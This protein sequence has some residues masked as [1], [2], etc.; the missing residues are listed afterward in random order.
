MAYFRNELAAKSSIIPR[1]LDDPARLVQRQ[2]LAELLIDLF[3]G[4]ELR[5]FVQRHYRLSKLLP[6]RTESTLRFA[7]A[8]VDLLDERSELDEELFIRLMQSRP[9]RALDIAKAAAG[10]GIILSAARIASIQS[11][12]LEVDE[13]IEADELGNRFRSVSSTD[14]GPY[15][16]TI[17]IA[18]DAH[19]LESANELERRLKER[20]TP[21]NVAIAIT[22]VISTGIAAREIFSRMAN[23]DVLVVLLSPSFLNSAAATLDATSALLTLSQSARLS[24]MAVICKDCDWRATAFASFP[25]RPSLGALADS[26]QRNGL[27]WD[28]VVSAIL[29][30]AQ[31]RQAQ[32]STQPQKSAA[33][34]ESDK[35]TPLQEH[36][37][38]DVFKTVGYPSVTFV[39]PT[40]LSEMQDELL[41]SGR[42]LVVEGPSG[43]GKTVAVEHALSHLRDS[44]QQRWPVLWLRAKV[45]ADLKEALAIPTRRIADLD[46]HI[47]IDDFQML[48]LSE[49][50]RIAKFAKAFADG[51][52]NEAKITLIGISR[53]QESLTH[54]TPD[55]ATR[56][57]VIRLGR[58]PNDKL[59]QLITKG[60]QAL[61]VR[62]RRKEE[63]ALAANGSFVVAQMLCERALRDNQVKRT[64]AAR[65]DIETDP[66]TVIP[67]VVRQLSAQFHPR[68]QQFAMLDQ[69]SEGPR[70]GTV[71]I[72]WHIGREPE[73]SID[74]DDVRPQWPNL[75]ESLARMLER[76]TQERQNGFNHEWRSLLD[77]DPDTGQ[78]AIDDPKLGFYLRYLDWVD[79]GQRCGIKLKRT[80]DGGLQFLD[81]ARTIA[82]QSPTRVISAHNDELRVL[83]LSDFHFTARTAWDSETVLDRLTNDIVRLVEAG[84][85]PDLLIITGDVANTGKADEYALAR[86]FLVDALLPAA[87]L[88]TASLIIVPGNH[89][90]DR[91][92]IG[93]ST[94]ALQKDLLD[95]RRQEDV[96][97]ALLNARD[98][99]V[100]LGRHA[101]F[102][103]FLESLQV[104]ARTW[105]LPWGAVSLEVR[106]LRVHV[107][108]LCSSWLSSDDSDKGKLLLGLKQVNEV[109][110][111]AK[112]ADVVIAAM[113][114][115]WTYVADFDEVS[116][117]EIYRNAAIVLRG[118]LHDAAHLQSQ[119]STHKDVIEI[120]A[121]ASYESSQ[122]P[123]AYHYLTIDPAQRR[124]RIFPRQWD[125]RRRDWSAD[126][127]L[128]QKEWGEFELRR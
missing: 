19:D 13:A 91:T 29:L 30:V 53:T 73:G 15:P 44:G 120:A 20:T 79:F 3:S 80:P 75:S 96:A 26:D 55:L 95:L 54:S 23:A 77:C 106:G 64:A 6:A 89:D 60:E 31:G 74:V 51:C 69:A 92:Q 97:Q 43:V 125:R 33:P 38:G 99:E 35:P 83:H 57:Q 50:E 52:R 114:H 17:S 122:H 45:E 109:F 84:K 66:A 12:T 128:F 113:H 42:V 85:Q 22:P 41:V 90:A 28:E 70:G 40:T 71:A 8:F 36:S 116:Q 10:L 25:V 68:L 9:R 126:L 115:P 118:H 27:G 32:G 11:A 87:K 21:D 108:A 4:V 78:I 63:F 5:D 65:R 76:I 107:A 88:T 14:S 7:L 123:N 72:L 34:N 48:P 93:R 67:A 46:G 39:G 1:P 98:R 47:V 121:G 61:N 58:E 18:A 81:T 101:A 105:D 110:Q 49:R 119:G 117:S 100:L 62:F 86:Q 56:A 37:T 127:N 82:A 2:A 94:S 103:E 24:I 112:H 16:I 102:V 104:G 59:V 124:L 111:G